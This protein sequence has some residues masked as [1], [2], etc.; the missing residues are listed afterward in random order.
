MKRL[1]LMCL[2]SI[3]LA[4]CD[5]VD[6]VGPEPIPS[7]LDMSADWLC[8]AGPFGDDLERTTECWPK[9]APVLATWDVDT[10][11]GGMKWMLNCPAWTATLPGLDGA[12]VNPERSRLCWPTAAG[13]FPASAM[14][15]MRWPWTKTDGSGTWVT[16][17]AVGH[18]RSYTGEVPT[19]CGDGHF[20]SRSEVCDGSSGCRAG[21]Q[22][23]SDCAGC[24][25]TP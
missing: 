7:G 13:A 22:C 4:A 5:P 3:V 12:G 20:N 25:R 14:C 24:M 19:V 11:Y 15:S 17:R 6:P 8:S 16:D 2:A 10:R 18:C 1:F 9:A 21:Y 23:A